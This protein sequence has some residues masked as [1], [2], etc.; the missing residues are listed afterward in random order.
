MTYGKQ[1]VWVF[2]ALSL[3]AC[4]GEDKPA[5]D[6]AAPKPQGLPTALSDN[7]QLCQTYMDTT[8][9]RNMTCD[10]LSG[11]PEAEVFS[12][13]DLAMKMAYSSCSNVTQVKDTALFFSCLRA[14]AAR[15]CSNLSS[16]PECYGLFE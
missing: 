10:R 6:P 2:L 11:M 8:V 7:E 13:L 12:R 16:K 1:I 3:L 14:Q 4:G 15:P 9:L 5:T